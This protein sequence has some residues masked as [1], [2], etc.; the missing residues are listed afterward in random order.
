M[1][2]PIFYCPQCGSD[3]IALK[4]QGG[5]HVARQICGGCGYIHYRN[6]TVIAGCII[7]RDGKYLF[8]RRA[9]EP[10][11]GKWSFP[12]GF[13]ENGETAEEAAIREVLEETGAKVEILGPYSIFSVPH[14]NQVY[15]IYRATLIDFVAEAGPESDKVVFI[16]KEDIPWSDMTYPA[17]TQITARYLEEKGKGKFGLYTGCY[18][19]GLVHQFS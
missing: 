12:A 2:Q 13:M 1:N 10:M 18:I 4:M 7:E 11:K 14:M 3:D 5:D 19:K 16:D 9:I 17:I 15:I 6:P 8:C